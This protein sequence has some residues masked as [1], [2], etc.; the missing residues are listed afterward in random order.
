M[1]E[2]A[3]EMMVIWFAQKIGNTE[4]GTMRYCTR[5]EGEHLIRVSADENGP[6]VQE[7]SLEWAL[8]QGREIQGYEHEGLEETGEL[9][10]DGTPIVSGVLK[11]E[12]TPEPEVKPVRRRG[13]PAGAKNKPK[14]P[15]APEVGGFDKPGTDADAGQVDPDADDDEADDEAGVDGGDST[16]TDADEF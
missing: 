12:K 2:M 9:D 14:A 13:R 6:L 8:S 11:V 15:P 5:I 1:T 3:A 16:S 10:I 4:M 7:V